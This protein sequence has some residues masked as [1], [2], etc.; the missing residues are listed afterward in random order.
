MSSVSKPNN[1]R[2]LYNKLLEDEIK[3]DNLC[4]EKHI[5]VQLLHRYNNIKDAAQ[6]VINHIANIEGTTVTEIHKRLNLVE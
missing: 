4:N 3:I 5:R 6:I 1:N 2:E